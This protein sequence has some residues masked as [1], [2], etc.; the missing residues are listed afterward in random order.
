MEKNPKRIR[1]AK[2]FVNEEWADGVD[3]CMLCCFAALTGRITHQTVVTLDT[4]QHGVPFVD[5]ALATVIRKP[6]RFRKRVREQKCLYAADFHASVLSVVKRVAD[7]NRAAMMAVTEPNAKGAAG[8]ILVH[9][10]PARA[11]AG[12]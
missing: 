8:P 12:N 3:D 5:N 1:V 6:D 4:D 10:I 11:L 2:S 9:R 7:V